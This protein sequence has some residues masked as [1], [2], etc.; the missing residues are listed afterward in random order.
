RDVLPRPDRPGG[1]ALQPPGLHRRPGEPR[2]ARTRRH[3]RGV[4]P[5]RLGPEPPDAVRDRAWPGGGRGRPERGRSA[6]RGRTRPALHR[7][8]GRRVVR[9]VP[10]GVGR[11]TVLAGGERA[12][13]EPV[14]RPKAPGDTPWPPAGRD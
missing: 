3:D 11:A 6:G 1:L 7:I 8:R 10:P 13:A 14:R 2:G 4:P 5:P 9:P 12:V